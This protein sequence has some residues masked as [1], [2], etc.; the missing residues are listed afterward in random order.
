MTELVNANEQ[1]LLERQRHRISDGIQFVTSL[2]QSPNGWRVTLTL[3]TD[4]V[5]N[6]NSDS[7]TETDTELTKI[8]AYYLREGH[9]KWKSLPNSWSEYIPLAKECVK[10][11]HVPQHSP[12]MNSEQITSQFRWKDLP[13]SCKCDIDLV[14]LAISNNYVKWWEDI[15]IELR[16]NEDIAFEA[17]KTILRWNHKYFSNL[18]RYC[19]LLNREFFRQCIEQEKIDDWDDLPQEYRTDIEFARSISYF[20]SKSLTYSILDEFSE[21][22][23][24]RDIWVKILQSKP[25]LHHVGSLLELFAPVTITS[26]RQLMFQSCQY[27]TVLQSVDESLG[28]DQSFLTE[29]LDHYPHQLIYLDYDAQSMF[30]DLVLSTL[31]P[32]CERKLPSYQL[33]K[34]VENLNL[35]FWNERANIIAWFTAGL[36]H[37]RT[38]SVSYNVISDEY[39]VDE[40][41]MLRIAE[42]CQDE[43]REGSFLWTSESLRINKEFMKKVVQ[44]D[45]ELLFCSGM[46]LQTDFDLVLFVIAN[47]TKMY[48][49]YKEYHPYYL[50]PFFEQVKQRL[51]TH[52]IYVNIILRGN[53]QPQCHLSMLGHGDETSFSFKKTIAEY[54]DVPTGEE[55]HLLR[56]CA[57][58]GQEYHG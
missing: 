1:N 32:F 8:L 40:E 10:V 17:W 44:F 56:R 15:P 5:Y 6:Q 46:D 38:L 35:S 25:I 49:H 16:N 2:Q 11:Q 39:R 4:S 24:E 12:F 54:L 20:P 14:L 41:M 18:L 36:P 50:P 47:S 7:L 3:P 33:R 29:V 58:L 57:V 23:N 51:L 21:L 22:T 45:P 28:H 52:H 30:P 34:L 9:I 31:K 37:P 13:D 48:K 26:D 42:H 43:Y 27:D 55:L 53:V 19:P